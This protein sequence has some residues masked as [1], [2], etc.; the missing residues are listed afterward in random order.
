MD[1]IG[2]IK[3]LVRGEVILNQDE[4]NKLHRRAIDGD[5]D[6]LNKIFNS[7]VYW[8]ITLSIVFYKVGSRYRPTIELDDLVQE[9][10]VG[11]LEGINKFEPDRGYRMTTYCYYHIK[12]RC[13]GFC[14][15]SGLIRVPRYITAEKFKERRTGPA[16]KSTIDI[17]EIDTS[18]LTNKEPFEMIDNKEMVE[19]TLNLVTKQIDKQVIIDKFLHN[20]TLKEIGGGL[21][22]SRQ[23]VQQIIARIIEDIQE[24]ISGDTYCKI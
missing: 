22:V 15:D 24:H 2:G 3:E 11:L 14:Y 6:A 8:A 17:D 18:F 23:R 20:K 7:L 5:E 13:L 1:A 10:M 16:F 9:G 4:L 19:Y 21:G 12:K